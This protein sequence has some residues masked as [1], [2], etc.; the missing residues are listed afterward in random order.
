VP[1]EAGQNGGGVM[2][3]FSQ[4][5]HAFHRAAR[6][7]SELGKSDVLTLRMVNECISVGVDTEVLKKL[8]PDAQNAIT[9]IME[10]DMTTGRRAMSFRWAELYLTSQ[11]FGKGPKVFKPTAAE[12]AVMQHVQLNIP[13]S[14]YVQPFGT[15]VIEIPDKLSHTIKFDNT[16]SPEFPDS[17][18]PIFLAVNHVPGVGAVI[19]LFFD[20][21]TGLKG[22][23]AEKVNR[24]LEELLNELKGTP[25]G[26]PGLLSTTDQEREL[27]ADLCKACMNYCLLLDEVGHK[28]VGPHNPKFYERLKDKPNLAWQR[29]IHPVYYEISQHVTLCKTV[30]SVSD[31]PAQSTGRVLPPHHRRGHYRQQKYGPGCSL[32]KR[33]RIPPVFVNSHLFLGDMSA[34]TVEYV[35]E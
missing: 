33:V 21:G 32:T 15:V 11:I 34:T 31:L 14:D 23:L 2:K 16:Q 1:L 6:V 35:K 20:S 26:G 29:R 19:G 10:E 12:L 17:H 24:D 28:K 5:A 22:Y 27:S 25:V 3:T 8:S 9:T 13:L 18:R 7:M 4:F 30:K